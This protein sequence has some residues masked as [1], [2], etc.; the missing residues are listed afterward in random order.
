[1]PTETVLPYVK[2]EGYRTVLIDSAVTVLL[3]TETSDRV[4]MN[5][6]RVDEVPTGEK[7]ILKDNGSFDTIPG[8]IPQSDRQKTLEFSIELRPDVALGI[9]NS[10]IRTIS[11]LPESRKI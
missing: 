2:S 1:M 11:R 8:D 9:A 6:T 5:F 4:V 10:L 3:A 7:V